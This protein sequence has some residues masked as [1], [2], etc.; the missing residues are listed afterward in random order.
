MN[1]LK[2]I[3]IKWISLESILD[4]EQPSKYIVSS[5]EYDDEYSIPV[6]TAGQTF[7]LGYTNEEEGI[8]EASKECPVIIFDDFTT[9][10]KWVDFRFKVKSSAMKMLRLKNPSEY[11]LK[12][13][14]YAI[15]ALNYVPAEHSRQWISTFSKVEIPVPD[16]ETQKSISSKLTVFSELI[17]KLNEELRFRKVQYEFYR[18]RVLQSFEDTEEKKL[19]DIVEFRNGKGHEKVIVEDGKYV[20]VNSKFI[21][22]NGIVKKYSDMQISPLYVD[23]ILMVMSDLPHGKALAKCYLV[24]ENDK[25]TLNQRIGAFHVKDKTEISTKYLFY[26]LDRNLQL[27]RYDNGVDQTN[28]RKDDILDILI[29]IPSYSQQQ[30]IVETLDVFKTLCE[31]NENGMPAEIQ[32]RQLQYDYYL[33]SLFEVE[34]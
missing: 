23:D 21:S 20:V 10:T 2:G 3:N 34:E 8:Y 13:I 30:K 31:D 12:Y 9:S 25:Y 28:L 6:L 33:K 29:P 5:T 4:Y 24:D 11:D 19:R 27:L 14:Y 22:T 32:A 1:I 26:V 7:I 15:N 17:N 18:E 16:L